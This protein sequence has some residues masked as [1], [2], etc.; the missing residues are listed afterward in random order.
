[1]N[2]SII[3]PF[4]GVNNI[5]HSNYFLDCIVNSIDLTT[6]LSAEYD[7][8]LGNDHYDSAADQLVDKNKLPLKQSEVIVINHIGDEKD[9]FSGLR[10]AHHIRLDSSLRQIPIVLIGPE[11]LSTI[12]TSVPDLSQILLTKGIGYFLS[13]K[14]FMPNVAALKKDLFLSFRTAKAYQDNFLDRIVIRSPEEQQGRHGI[15]NQWGAY[16]MAQVAGLGIS[17]FRHPKTLYFKY[18]LAQ[19]EIPSAKKRIFPLGKKVLFIDDNHDKGWNA[20][21]R[22][23]FGESKVKSFKS[24][25]E[26]KDNYKDEKEGAIKDFEQRIIDDEFDLIFLD[27]YLGERDKTG[28]GKSLLEKIK[29]NKDDEQNKIEGLNPVVPVIMFTAS[30]KA[31]NMDEL[32]EAG[33][34]GY[35]VKEHPE[36][37]HDLD[38]S[39]KNFE[40]FHKTV[41]KCLDKGELLRK[42]WSKI[43]DIKKNGIIENKIDTTGKEQKNKERIN[44]RLTMFLGLLKKAKEQTKF[45]EE[46][47]FYSEWELAFLTLWSTLNEIQEA[48]YDKIIGINNPNDGIHLEVEHPNGQ[49]IIREWLIKDQTDRLLWKEGLYDDNMLII[50]D[51]KYKLASF[52]NFMFNSKTKRFKTVEFTR[53]EISHE[54]KLFIQ[55]AFLIQNSNI[56]KNGIHCISKTT[57]EKKYPNIKNENNLRNRITDESKNYEKGLLDL[58]LKLNKER[59]HLYLTHGDESTSSN[60]FGDYQSQRRADGDWQ[61][62]IKQLFEIVY[63]LCTGK[64]CDG[65]I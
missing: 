59:N 10:I 4:D 13:E 17:N 49:M 28:E 64:D 38:F 8:S 7:L 11:I 44:E 12:L 40:N 32:Y 3:E 52:S 14:S 57:I 51:E 16:R 65:S 6:Y 19:S 22:A 55:I 63:F 5:R 33:A 15:A 47:F 42:Y 21:L 36:T 37:A 31:W 46:T 56:L 26:A 60:Y 61:N 41:K 58:L 30:N 20:C 24:W 27:F 2:I 39:V 50:K 48:C 9:N 18:L 45:D 25:Q 29:G 34:D 53:T 35:Y 43:Q 1:M 62:N 54:T 23:F